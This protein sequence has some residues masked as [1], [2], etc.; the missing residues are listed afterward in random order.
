MTHWV[1]LYQKDLKQRSDFFYELQL[2]SE[3][4]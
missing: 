1:G 2:E 4:L 3:M